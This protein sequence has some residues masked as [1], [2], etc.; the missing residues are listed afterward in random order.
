MVAT[1]KSTSLSMHAYV[2]DTQ[3]EIENRGKL[4]HTPYRWRKWIKYFRSAFFFFL[5]F[6]SH[7]R[8][9]NAKLRH[10]IK[11]KNSKRKNYIFFNKYFFFFNPYLT[12]VLVSRN[13]NLFAYRVCWRGET[14]LL[15]TIMEDW[16]TQEKIS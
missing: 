1:D 15:K 11:I 4:R 6:L 16:K 14:T 3:R 5:F 7:H 10:W 9:T 13:Q 12:R 2:I 8:I